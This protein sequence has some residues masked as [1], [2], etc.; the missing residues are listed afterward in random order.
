MGDKSKMLIVSFMIWSQ[1]TK[2]ISYYNNHYT[3]YTSR[4]YNNL[5]KSIRVYNYGDICG[6][7]VIIVGNYL[8]SYLTNILGKGVNPISL[9]SAMGT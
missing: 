3:T 5:L 9:L 8:L 4:W 7:M 2:S 6:V 1:F